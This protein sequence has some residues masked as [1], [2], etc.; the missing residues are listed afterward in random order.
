MLIA[1]SGT[2]GSG[3]TTVGKLLAE[4]L[5]LKFTSTGKLFREMAEESGKNLKKFSKL[6]E[7]D[8]KIDK[9]LDARQTKLAKKGN[10]VLEGRLSCFLPEIKADYRIWVDAAKDERAKRIAKRDKTTKAKALKELDY[11]EASEKKRYSTYYQIDLDDKSAYDLQIDST[12]KTPEDSLKLILNL[13]KKEAINKE[14]IIKEEKKEGKN[15]DLKQIGIGS[16]CMKTMG[17]DKGECVI[18]DIKEN[19]ALVTGPKSLTGVRRRYINL[20]HLTPTGKNIKINKEAPDEAVANALGKTLPATRPQKQQSKQLPKKPIKRLTI[21][22]KAK[23]EAPIKE[24][25][26]VANTTKTKKPTKSAKT[27]TPKAAKKR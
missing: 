25:K 21:P 27:E 10:L 12:D 7:K 4:A 5:G 17:R 9:E 23:K 18:L 11:R 14:V 15:M 20:A 3:K 6:A 26:T 16:M 24:K 22:K 13:I 8:D 1:I 19:R 2:P